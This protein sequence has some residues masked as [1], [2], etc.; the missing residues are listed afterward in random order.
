MFFVLAARGDVGGGAEPFGHLAADGADG[1]G[2]RGD[3]RPAAGFVADA[4][5]GAEGALAGARA[6]DG[7]GHQVAVVGVHQH[8]QPGGGERAVPAQQQAAA[9]DVHFAPVRIGA[10]D[11]VGGGVDHGGQ[12]FF[13]AAAGF[14]VLLAFGDVAGGA[15]D[16]FHFA[17]GADDGHQQVVV[18]A[19]AV[20]A[21]ERH[22]A[23]HGLA[24]GDDLFDLAVVHGGVPGF[25]T[26]FQA[27]P[28]DGFVP[29]LAPHGQQGGVGVGEAVLQVPHVDQVGRGL[30][31]GFV[32]AEA[33]LRRGV[34]TA[35]HRGAVH[36]RGVF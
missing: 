11:Q 23:A 12:P 31:E 16:G 6:G 3:P 26:Q 22:V 34:R 33:L 19:A 20:G 2:A 4:V 36:G 17:I 14:F 9:H 29:G 8:L 24:G 15:G 7:V 18:D 1:H 28:A 10:V 25:V 35:C 5:F 13:A 32:Q 27:V 30:Q 21:V